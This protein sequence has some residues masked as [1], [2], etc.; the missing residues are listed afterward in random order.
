MVKSCCAVGCHNKYKK[1]SG[2]Q[3]YRIPKD[4][5]RH[6]RWIAAISHKDWT[7]S[8]FTCLCSKHF[9]SKSKNDN[10][11]SP[12]Y[13]PRVFNHTDSPTKWKLQQNQD[14]FERRQALKRRR[15]D[16]PLES[17]ENDGTGPSTSTTEIHLDSLTDTDG[18]LFER[19]MKNYDIQQERQ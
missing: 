10:P 19:S 1:G 18:V 6:A 12:D 16:K 9:V 17:A 2:I 15:I 5:N 13:V 4:P 14:N 7:P 11:L 8:E 3:F